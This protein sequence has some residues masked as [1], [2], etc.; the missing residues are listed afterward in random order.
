[1]PRNLPKLLNV[2]LKKVKMAMA[3]L[4]IKLDKPLSARLFPIPNKKAG[5]MTTFNS[6]YLVDCKIFTVN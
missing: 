2:F 1:M 4:A 6:P 3:T 5:E